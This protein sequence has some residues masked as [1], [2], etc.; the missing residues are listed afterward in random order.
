MRSAVAL[1]TVAFAATAAPIPKELKGSDAERLLGTWETTAAFWGTDEHAPD[2]GMIW[3]IEKDKATRTR[4]S[5]DSGTATWEI[6]D[7]TDPKCFDWTRSEGTAFVGVYEF[8]GEQLRVTLIDK[9]LG[10][11]KKVGPVENG[12]HFVFQRK[13]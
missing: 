12:F 8:D 5:G 13:K 2:L 7:R 6:D 10:R 9:T 11:P 1:L 4:T 3:V